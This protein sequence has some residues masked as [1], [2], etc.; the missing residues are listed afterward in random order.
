MNLERR[1]QKLFLTILK[2][3]ELYFNWVNYMVREY[4]SIVLLLKK[5]SIYLYKA[6]AKKCKAIL[7][8][9]KFKRAKLF[10]NKWN[11]IR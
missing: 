2:I 9:I 10:R 1:I 8:N 7:F 5:E 3:I 4:I 11:K 6:F